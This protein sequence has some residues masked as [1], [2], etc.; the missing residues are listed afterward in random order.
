MGNMH[1]HPARDSPPPMEVEEDELDSL[2]TSP[3]AVT[4][5]WLRDAADAVDALRNEELRAAYNAVRRASA[6]S[7][8]SLPAAVPSSV[9][10]EPGASA[11]GTSLHSAREG[12]SSQPKS[13]DSGPR[14][15]AE[16][17]GRDSGPR[18]RLRVFETFSAEEELSER[19]APRESLS[20]EA[21]LAAFR[22]AQRRAQGL[23]EKKK[24]RDRGCV[25]CTHG[26]VIS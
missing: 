6:S 18:R 16:T 15:R 13:E 22:K 14:R 5:E 23:S 10:A 24:Q 19:S 12:S 7:R 21:A 1:A 9:T 2:P 26:C 11:K 17:A 3:A 20:L 8:D 4:E 25:G